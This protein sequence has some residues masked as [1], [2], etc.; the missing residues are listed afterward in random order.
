MKLFYGG[1][2]RK[3]QM[4]EAKGVAGRRYR[5][6]KLGV[7]SGEFGMCADPWLFAVL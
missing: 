6:R 1:E 5:K 4:N 2:I 7:A 3:G